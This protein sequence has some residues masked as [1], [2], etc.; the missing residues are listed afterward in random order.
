[1]LVCCATTLT[2]HLRGCRWRGV[3][4]QGCEEDRQDAGKAVTGRLARGRGIFPA[5]DGFFKL[6][7]TILSSDALKTEK[8]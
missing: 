8:A 4:Q 1:M 2:E 5:R 3:A 7:R 6:R